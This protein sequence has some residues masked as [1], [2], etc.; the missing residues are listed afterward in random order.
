[1]FEILVINQLNAL[2]W[3]I[4]KIILRYTVNKTSKFENTVRQ[5]HPR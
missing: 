5:I 4:T 1:M 3:L 2:S